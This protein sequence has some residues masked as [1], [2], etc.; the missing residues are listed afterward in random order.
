MQ[1]CIGCWVLY[2]TQLLCRGAF[3][4]GTGSMRSV[5]TG[6]GEG[7]SVNVG[8][9]VGGMTGKLGCSGGHCSFHKMHSGWQLRGSQLRTQQASASTQRQTCTSKAG[10]VSKSA[11]R[12]VSHRLRGADADYIAAFTHVFLPIAYEFSP[13]LV[14]LSAGYGVP[15]T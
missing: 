8:W 4:P 6:A 1:S 10:R 15:F 9:P 3:Y 13:D 11:S 5:G 2:H 14:I 7:F 12:N